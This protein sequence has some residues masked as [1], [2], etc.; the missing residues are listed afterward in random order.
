MVRPR[1][2]GGEEAVA[3][4]M[5]HPLSV[6]EAAGRR[7]I[8]PGSTNV[9]YYVDQIECSGRGVHRLCEIKALNAC[10][11]CSCFWPVPPVFVSVQ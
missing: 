7:L 8:A 5:M 3:Q 6:R 9:L 2:G 1:R 4:E 10:F 11:S